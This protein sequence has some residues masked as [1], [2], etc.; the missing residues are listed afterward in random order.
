MIRI[1]IVDDQPIV[2]QGLAMVLGSEGDIEVVASGGNGF[3][4]IEICSKNFVDVVLMDIKMPS[5]NGVEATKRIKKQYPNVKIIILTTFNEDEYIFEALKHGASGY[6]LKDALPQK[7]VEAIRVVYNGGA[8]IQPDVAVKVVEKL[9]NYGEKQ[10]IL[11][12][13]IEDL[14]EREIDII[15]C[16][17]QGKSNKEIAKELFISEGTVKNHITNVLNKLSLR[18]RTQLAIFSINNH[19]V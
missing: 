2:R 19:L 14:T 1:A 11:D 18:D 8:Q 12:K 3:E 10:G 7:I 17:G 16:V 13:R 6:L 15:R 9:K 5:L 4:A